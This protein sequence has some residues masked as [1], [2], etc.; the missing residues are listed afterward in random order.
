MHDGGDPGS[1]PYEATFTVGQT[2]GACGRMPRQR[3]GC[4]LGREGEKRREGK[5]ERRSGCLYELSQD[6]GSAVLA[7]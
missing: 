3:A 6:V 7:N 2:A 1:T 4:K 5:G